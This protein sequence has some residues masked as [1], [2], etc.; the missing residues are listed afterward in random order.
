MEGVTELVAGF[1]TVPNTA[2]AGWIVSW[3][4][5]EYPCKFEMQ[6]HRGSAKAANAYDVTTL[7]RPWWSSS[8]LVQVVRDERG[9]GMRTTSNS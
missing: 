3:M 4:V 5:G 8:V 2:W 9:G 7:R 6:C 1:K